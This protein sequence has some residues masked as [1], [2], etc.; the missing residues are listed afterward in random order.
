[1]HE[2]GHQCDAR[3]CPPEHQLNP[4]PLPQRIVKPWLDDPVRDA[5]PIAAQ[6]A[7]VHA[8]NHGLGF[9]AH[10]NAWHWFEPSE[11]V[12][13]SR[14]RDFYRGLYGPVIETSVTSAADWIN[15]ARA[16]V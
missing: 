2:T 10:R 3:A 9:A 11:G 15:E 14:R 6:R 13:Y 7:Y 1:M 8:M 4:P 16:A 12:I 5:G